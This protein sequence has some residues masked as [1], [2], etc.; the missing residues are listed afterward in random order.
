MIDLINKTVSILNGEVILWIV[1][2]FMFAYFSY[3]EYCKS[4]KGL[5]VKKINVGFPDLNEAFNTV[6]EAII[7]SDKQSHSTASIS[8]LLAFLTALGSLI[9]SISK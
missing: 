4:K 9:L 6:K 8:Y 5:H 7:I 3:S 2:S 1:F